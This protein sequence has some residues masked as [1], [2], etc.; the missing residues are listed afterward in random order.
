MKTFQQAGLGLAL[1]LTG[2]CACS[3]IGIGFG[4]SESA[5]VVPPQEN[6]DYEVELVR[7]FARVKRYACDGT[8]SSDKIEEV[9]EPSKWISIIADDG[10]L[11][12][13]ALIEHTRR[14]SD[15]GML[16]YS[17]SGVSFYIHKSDTWLGIQV[18]EGDN[19]FDY[20]LYDAEGE[21]RQSGRIH[22][23]VDYSERRLEETREV[24]P[25]PESCV[26]PRTSV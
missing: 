22:V 25:T 5:C 18:D 4:G 11:V 2:A 1:A 26:E 16:S 21:K 13:H 6:G 17:S 15:S 20:T 24:H 10:F 7:E 14:R 12:D 3:S 8:L 9:S 23:N 19:E